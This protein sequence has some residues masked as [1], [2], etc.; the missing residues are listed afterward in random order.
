MYATHDPGPTG[1]PK[2]SR[3]PAHTLDAMYRTH[4]DYVVAVFG[5][6]GTTQPV[7]EDLA[8]DVFIVA[9]RRID[10]FRGDSAVRTWLHAI[11]RRV[12]MT[13]RRS[14]SRRAAHLQREA[15]APRAGACGSALESRVHVGQI[16]Q[17]LDPA[18][19]GI[20][21]DAKVYRMSAVEIAARSGISTEAVYSR[22]RRATQR[23]G[24]SE[25]GGAIRS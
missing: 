13:W 8:Q 1:A 18:T 25:S 5:R 22:L 15:S 11:A 14:E 19:R 21:I 23:I 6:L 9:A 16:L 3:P 4:R 10:S 17:D 12:W 24:A 7:A 2:P 20:L